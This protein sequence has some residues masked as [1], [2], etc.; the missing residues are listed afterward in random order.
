[1]VNRQAQYGQDPNR[2]T[3]V[4]TFLSLNQS[5][6]ELERLVNSFSRS[7][8]DNERRLQQTLPGMIRTFDRI[9]KE[10]NS[11]ST[12]KLSRSQAA[13]LKVM[14]ANEKNILKWLNDLSKFDPRTGLSRNE[15]NDKSFIQYASIFEDIMQKMTSSMEKAYKQWDGYNRT[16][17]K[18]RQA[19]GLTPIP[20][21]KSSH[22]PSS[23]TPGGPNFAYA[24]LKQ[25]QSQ[26]NSSV[27]PVVRAMGIIGQMARSSGLVNSI[28]GAT[29]RTSQSG[30]Y[31]L[32]AQLLNQGKI[33]P[34]TARLLAHQIQTQWVPLIPPSVARQRAQALSI[35]S[36]A[37]QHG[38]YNRAQA[39]AGYG[40]AGPNGVSTQPLIGAAKYK[41]FQPGGPAFNPPNLKWNRRLTFFGDNTKLFQNLHKTFGSI[42]I[43]GSMTRHISNMSAGGGALRDVGNTLAKSFSSTSFLGKAGKLLAGPIGVAIG[44]TAVAVGAIYK[45]LKKSSP[46]LQAVTD[47][48]E[49]AWNLMWMPFG[50]ALGQYL[51]P[52]AEDMI[53]FA[54]MFNELFSD[55]SLDKLMEV[56][57]AGLQM[58]WGMLFDAGNLI[59]SLLI[60]GLFAMLGDFFR[61]IGLDGVAD[62]LD[63]IKG[64]IDSI[65]DF[66]RNLPTNIFN[67]LKNLLPAIKD[68]IF[69]AMPGG[70]VMEAATNGDLV[71]AG[72]SAWNNTIGN[73]TGF[74]LASGGIVSS[75]TIAMIGE[76]GPEAVIPLDKVGGMGATYIININGDVYG[77]ND[78]ETRIERVVQRTANKSYYR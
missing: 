37:V 28:P 38:K 33:R 18:T 19:Y 62:W 7:L 74:K 43:I 71:S 8:T 21:R 24:Y 9:E 31:S 55:F 29:Q 54:I 12:G 45:Q 16:I 41:G 77:V 5:F 66:V 10:Y 34:N 40:G 47:I 69:G 49:L 73:W 63:N 70:S 50:N 72:K 14:L 4:S 67:A 68:A 32:V 42:P 61:S 2:I 20:S 78:L 64:G 75:P 26:I 6:R 25:Q 48:M 11:S 65:K 17:D 58:I 3:D 52:L 51:I 15:R 56:Y 30:A 13:D 44:A 39:Y 53:N 35:A 22:T 60:D 27:S 46:V 36:G 23:A 59:S 1:M 57:Y 76:A